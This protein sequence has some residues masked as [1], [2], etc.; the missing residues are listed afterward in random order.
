MIDI[1]IIKQAK[2]KNQVKKKIN[3]GN[4]EM[5]EGFTNLWKLLCVLFFS[6]FSK[7]YNSSLYRL[8]LMTLG[9]SWLFYF[10]FG[11]SFLAFF[12]ELIKRVQF[13][14]L[15]LN[16]QSEWLCVQL[17]FPAQWHMHR[18]SP[19]LIPLTLQPHTAPEAI[20]EIL[21]KGC[22]TFPQVTKCG[23]ILVSPSCRESSESPK[24]I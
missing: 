14:S 12:S 15:D 22:L 20:I 4:L 18:F 23:G 19:F 1:T 17:H 10:T 9:I 3:I 7:I 2:K 21:L 16:A 8:L 24:G 5:L 11:V 13:G 6:F